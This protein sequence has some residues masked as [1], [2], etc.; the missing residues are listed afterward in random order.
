MTNE[1][2]EKTF[3]IGKTRVSLASLMQHLVNHSAYHLGQ[4]APM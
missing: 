2:L 1:S 3:P 4:I